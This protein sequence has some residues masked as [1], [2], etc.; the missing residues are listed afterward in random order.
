MENILI[1]FLHHEDMEM[2]PVHLEF[3]AAKLLQLLK[4]HNEEEDISSDEW[5]FLN[6]KEHSYCKLM[7]A[8]ET[9]PCVLE[10]RHLC[11]FLPEICSRNVNYAHLKEV[12]D[13]LYELQPCHKIEKVHILTLFMNSQLPEAL[14]NHP[15]FEQIYF[16]PLYLNNELGNYPCFIEDT[17]LYSQQ[18]DEHTHECKGACEG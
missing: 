12:L 5:Q 10:C 8:L 18:C 17:S 15:I 13:T 11:L 6:F 3:F 4:M 7:E 1:K 14:L 16:Y 2:R 9:L